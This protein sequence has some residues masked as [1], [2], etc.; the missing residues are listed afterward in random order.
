MVDAGGGPPQTLCAAPGQNSGTWSTDGTI[1]F[2]MAEASGSNGLYRIPA[3]GGASERLEL[4]D[5]AGKRIV[6]GF[7]PRF[8]PDGRHFL[9]LGRTSTSPTRSLRAGTLG[10]PAT[11][12]I[13]PLD[14][15]VEYAPPGYLLWVREGTLLAQP[16]DASSRRLSGKPSPIGQDVRYFEGTG[17]ANFSTSQNGLLIYER[18]QSQLVQM[19]RVDRQ[20]RE[21]ESY[22]E[23][24]E[25]SS[26][27]LS[28][29]G[30]QFAMSVTNLRTQN[31]D[32]WIKD[33]ARNVSMRLTSSNGSAFNPVWSPD[34]QRVVFAADWD[35]VPHLFVQAIEATHE[36]VL[37]PPTGNVQIPTDWSP[38]G[39]FILYM[40]R[41]PAN[42][43]DVWALPTAGDRKP[44]P[45]A[46]TKF[47][48][49]S[50]VFSPDGR[51]IA[52]VSDE[53][54][55][56]EVYIQPFQRPGE[57]RR[58]SIG[59]GVEPQWRRDGKELFY[60]SA[61]TL[62]AVQVTPG[63]QLRTGTPAALFNIPNVDTGYD[64]FPD[65]QHFAKGRSVRSDDRRLPIVVVN[66][67]QGLSK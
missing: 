41:D 42:D 57:R 20:G 21:V 3:A 51:W 4:T 59:G 47:F 63:D 58:I 33:L 54:G 35:S 61:G 55:S 46:N 52:Y 8:L 15:R 32:L 18:Q 65:G 26:G 5:E 34:G 45:L 16:F 12:S 40:E 66:W 27:R 56:P 39:G 48:E 49:G 7:W 44:I 19:I 53:A 23:P 30:T 29:S 28:P 64:V 38:D 62:M 67:A 37:R 31:G 9:F 36:S 11:T 17:N 6:G 14:S 10:S 13:M 50:A 60:E 43:F 22:G 24:A 25:I 1:L 2:G